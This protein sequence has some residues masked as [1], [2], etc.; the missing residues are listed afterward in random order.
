MRL[1]GVSSSSFDSKDCHRGQLQPLQEIFETK[2]LSHSTTRLY[3]G[4]FTLETQPRLT[5]FD[6]KFEVQ[7]SK[8]TNLLLL[9]LIDLV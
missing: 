2:P 5:C 6:S 8:G 9:V 3:L 4:T 7:R 1:A